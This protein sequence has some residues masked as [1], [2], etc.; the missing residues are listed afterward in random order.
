M[1]STLVSPGV[2]VTVVDESQ[3]L[4]AAT[5]SVPFVVIATASN[6]LSADGTGIAPGTLAVNAGK[7]FL[8]TS[9][10]ALSANYGVPFFYQTTNGTPINGYELNEYGLLAAYSALGVTNQCYVLRADID[11]AALTASLTRPTG[12]PNNGTYWLDT[13]N[14]QW[15]LFTWNQVSGTFTNL[16]PSVITNQ[17][18]LTPSSTVPLQSYGSIGQYAVVATNTSNP[19]YF[20]RGGPTPSQSNATAITSLYNTWVQLGSAPWQ[21][22]WPTIQGTNTPSGSS[23]TA[24]DTFKIN[25]T[26]ITVP[27]SPTVSLISNAINAAGITG[28]YAANIGGSLNLYA[29][30][31][32][33]IVSTVTGLTSNG[34]TATV[35]FS[36]AVPTTYVVG[37]TIYLSGIVNAGI[38][39]SLYNGY[40]T[41]T[42]STTTS[43]S[44]AT[45]TTSAYVS[46][47][48]AINEGTV[49]LANNAG[50]SFAAL[51][52]TAGTYNAPTYQVSP[53]YTVPQWNT[54]S[55]MPEPTGSVWQKSNSVNQ[56]TSIVMKQYNS[57]LGLYVIQ[58]VTV[59]PSD[60]AALY[61]LD[62]S[63]GGQGIPTGTLYARSNPVSD[64][65][66]GYQI[67]ERYTTGPT[68]VTGSN[69]TQTFSSGQ[70]FS[71]GASQPG[72][73]VNQWRTVSL[74]SIGHSGN[75]TASDF[76]AAISAAG[77][78]YVSATINSAGA[79]VM[80]HSKGGD[81]ELVDLNGGTV[82]TDAGFTTSTFLCRQRYVNGAAAG[83]ALSNWVG[84]T[85]FTYTASDV[86]PDQD[87]TD[88]TYWYYSDATQVDIMIQNNGVWTGYQNCTSDSRGYDLS[89][90]NATGPIIS[91][92]PPLTQT[93]NTSPLVYGDLWVNTS[94]LEDYPILSRWQNVNGVDQ[95]VQID[96]TDAT[97]SN[98]ILFQDARWAPNGTT[99]PVSA[100][101]PTIQSLLTS[102]YLDPDA[103]DALLYPTGMLLWNT[104]RSG[105]N[106][107]TYQS[108]YFNNNTFPT[109]DWVSTTSYTIG[110][111]VQYDNIVYACI[112]N[113]S[114]QEP[115]TSPTYWSVQTVTNTWLTATGN[116]PDGS[117]YMGRQA[118]REIIVKAMKSAID[119]NTQIREEQNSY[120]LIA[121]PGYPE[122][123]PNMVA[124]NNEINNVAFSIIDTPLRLAPADI[125]TWATDNNGLGLPTGDGNLAAGDAYGGTFYPSCQTTDLSG[126]YCVTYPSHMMIRTII[127]SDEIA[128]PWLAPAGTRRGLVDNAFQLGYLNGITGVFET[129][130]VGQSLRDVLYEN[131][132]N[133]ITYIPGVGITN[134]GNKTLQATA[135]ALDRINVARLVC[136]IRTRLETIGKQYLFEPNDQI[137]RTEISNA[138]VSLMIDLVAKRGIYDY[139][140][141]CD[142]TNNTPTT[143]D[144]NQ[145]WVDI[146]IEPVKAV[147]FIYIPLRI[148]NTGAIA[149]Q[150]AA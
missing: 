114:N 75:P 31:T 91:A 25:N 108:N 24:G 102:N 19:I 46:G 57:T 60:N 111:Y 8:A 131:Q 126:N 98:G 77:I 49:V 87:P 6:K 99:D 18:Y 55:A 66:S 117:P 34:S 69:T 105:F 119:T 61:G 17:D 86:A 27:S 137:T 121:V 62:P 14:T 7:L 47:G 74:V 68:I 21:T 118:Q 13:V 36:T 23:L 2:Q 132:I 143:I 79:I 142:N 138:I 42:A 101:L 128:Y 53:S 56:G 106:V 146:A 52:L 12:S 50:T 48:T 5:N 104:R 58:S 130:G 84:S 141:V 96:N 32:A 120:N 136:F 88:G 59:Y 116:R 16:I 71:L 149:A 51:G 76:V 147:E 93:D 112:Q 9:Q 11:L 133:P 110:Q 4:P 1:A 115:D 82:V 54:F 70:S 29:D 92:T 90:T 26:L 89:Q 3:Y 97:Q 78:P 145:L 81:I 107:K 41:V 135:T 10:R 63:G 150:A 20:K 38:N 109:Y 15:G 148:E 28:V 124:L 39:A 44:F 83:L 123:A 65:T 95:W 35:T 103:P 43:V 45:T 140:V 73:A 134:F 40:F 30:T 125:V 127:R 129:L 37:S 122:L 67:L 144:Q 94:D 33:G 100:A 72:T 85:T 113:N 139:L 64:G 22:S 80:Q